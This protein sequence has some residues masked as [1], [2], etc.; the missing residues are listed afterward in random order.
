MQS[1]WFS[2]NQNVVRII[3]IGSRNPKLQEE[4]LEIH[5]MAIRWQIRI[6][7]E[8][9]PRELNQRA[10]QLSRIL[11]KDDWSIHPMVFQQLELLWGPHTIDR[12]A[13]HL[14][15]QLP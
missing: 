13:N 1:R 2:D 5:A 7:P 14:N 15:S 9:I 12:F 10:D 11:D 6:E 4:A 8:W 3:Q